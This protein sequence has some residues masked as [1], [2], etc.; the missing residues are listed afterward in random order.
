M[1]KFASITRWPDN[2]GFDTLKQTFIH[3]HQVIL[4]HFQDLEV[5][6]ENLDVRNQLIRLNHLTQFEATISRTAVNPI[7][8]P[9]SFSS[10]G[11]KPAPS[12]SEIHQFNI[13]KVGFTCIFIGIYRD[14]FRLEIS[15]VI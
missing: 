12:K 11:L 15:F 1:V 9:S 7:N 10:L 5:V 4:Y 3:K 14:Y 8:D 13:N 6:S 2:N